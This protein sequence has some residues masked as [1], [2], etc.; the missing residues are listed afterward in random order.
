MNQP[1][2]FIDPVSTGAGLLSITCEHTDVG[3]AF[4]LL[5]KAMNITA[6]E[7]AERVDVTSSAVNER[8]RDN[9][10]KLDFAAEYAALLGYRID[11][12]LF[13]LRKPAANPIAVPIGD[14]L[15]WI[16]AKRRSKK[17]SQ[18]KYAEML[19]MGHKAYKLT[20]NGTV[21]CHFDRLTDM[22]VGLGYR[23]MYAIVKASI[24][25]HVIERV[26]FAPT[27]RWISD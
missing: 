21:G 17:L 16:R 27:G 7:V 5:R 26:R 24:N 12:Y 4:R 14:I 3:L 18:E 22:I 23:P 25:H 10:M 13:A 11:V 1:L 19:Y 9:N 6:R 2:S 15:D 20:E 8:E